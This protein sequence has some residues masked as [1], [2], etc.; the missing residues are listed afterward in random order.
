MYPSG[1]TFFIFPQSLSSWSL[2]VGRAFKSQ[3]E[4]PR[5]QP[6]KCVGLQDGKTVGSWSAVW[7]T[8][9]ILDHNFT[10]KSF[11]V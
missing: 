1:L 4:Y 3:A 9:T 6:I 5:Q 2:I 10:D 8:C 11:L 7:Q